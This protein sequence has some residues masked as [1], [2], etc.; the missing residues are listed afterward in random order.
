MDTL[1][2]FRRQSDLSRDLAAVGFGTALSG[3]LGGLPMIAEIV[4]SSAN[5]NNGARTGW[6]N[7][8]HG[9]FILLSVLLAASLIDQ[10]PMASL[11][12]ILVFTGWGLASP[13]IFKATY[14][15]GKDQLLIFVVTILTT[16]AT[17]LLIGVLTGILTNFVLN[18]ITGLPIGSIVSAKIDVVQTGGSCTVTVGGAAVFSNWM[19]IKNKLD[20]LSSNKNIVVDFKTAKLVDH[21][22]MER[23]HQWQEHYENAGGHLQI[24]GL[25]KHIPFS[26]HH[27]AARRLVSSKH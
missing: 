5:V 26:T 3:M 8:F 15:I 2:R 13:R 10:I 7:F 16:L 4:R 24:I 9:A 22:V 1:D 25:D 21:T 11:A 12:A 17:D 6:S 27:L 14:K 18:I 23:L 20:S 19:G